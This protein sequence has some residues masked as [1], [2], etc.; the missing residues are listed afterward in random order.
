M[1]SA[2]PVLTKGHHPRAVGMRPK[3]GELGNAFGE[4]RVR[5]EGVSAVHVFGLVAGELHGHR[6]GDPRPLQ[7]PDR[8]PAKIMHETPG[9]QAALHAS[10][11][12]RRKS[13][14]T[15]PSR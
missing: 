2:L 8:R 12:T 15:R 3:R 9:T 11:H 6:A 5:D 13:L 10:A 7:L 14:I 4:V 1:S